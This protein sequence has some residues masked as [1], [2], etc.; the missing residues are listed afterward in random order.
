MTVREF[1]AALRAARRTYPNLTR[2]AMENLLVSYEQAARLA[3]DAV[4]RAEM[5]GHSNITTESWARIQRQLEQGAAIVREQLDVQIRKTLT[6]G[7]AVQSGVH[8]MYMV[9]AVRAAGAGNKITMLGIENMFSAVNERVVRSVVNRV[10]QDGYTYSQR[11]WQVGTQYQNDIKNLI[12]SGLSQGRDVI[13]IAKDLEGYLQEGKQWL[14]KRYGPN[15]IRGTKEFLSRIGDRIDARAL[16]LIRSELYMSIQEAAK[17]QGHVAP[18]CTDEYDFVLQAGRQ[19]WGCECPDIAANGP[20][21]YNEVPDY[22]H[23]NCFCTLRPRLRDRA[24]FI[25]DLTRWANDGDNVPYLDNWY[26]NIYSQ[27]A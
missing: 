20:Y 5:A 25:D 26:K 15:L 14:V 1:E 2:E 9:D 8:G 19:N 22:P 16:R 24:E 27:T 21:P 13:K 6:Q 3:A 17:Q 11:V 10:F 7:T 23:P 4:L 12:S 18:S